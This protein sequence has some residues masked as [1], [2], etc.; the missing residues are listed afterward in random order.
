[1]KKPPSRLGVGES[2]LVAGLLAA[3]DHDLGA[4]GD[5]GVDVV[6]DPLEC[7]AGDQRAVVGLG[8]QAVA[9]AQVVDPLD[10]PG[11]QPVRGLLADGHRDADGHA[12]LAG[13]AVA[14]ADEGVDGLVQVGVGHDDHVVL[15][16]AE[17]L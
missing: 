9:D 14:G 5:A 1:M 15:G 13:A 7:G 8:V 3:V 6:A 12:P 17:A 11:A 16:A 2:Q 10:E 4:G